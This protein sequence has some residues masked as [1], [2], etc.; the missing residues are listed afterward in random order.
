M[1]AARETSRDKARHGAP[2]GFETRGSEEAIIRYYEAAGP[3]YEAWSKNFN[4][5]FGF[6]RW[7]LNPFNRERMLEETTRQ[8]FKRLRLSHTASETA[9]D[10]GCGLG[11]SMRTGARFF[12]RLRLSG[13]TLVPWQIERAR[14]LTRDSGC[15]NRLSYCHGN[16]ESLPYAANQFDA[17]YAIESAVY[18]QGAGKENLVQ[19]A[20]RVLRS[21]GHFVIFDCFLKRPPEK[22]NPLVRYC[23]KQVCRGWAVEEM[24]QIEPFTNALCVAGFTVVEREDISWQV[25]PSVAHAPFV[26]LRFFC[27]KLLL[28]ERLSRESLHHLLSC[29]L[30]CLLGLDRRSFSYFLLTCR[31]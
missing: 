12:P 11:A 25:A 27:G 17:C 30:A 22:M 7:P 20:Y 1:K 29:A 18:A 9:V 3:D 13:V 21:G 16:Y 4:M 23:Y 10:L 8:V 6:W 5:H 2:G 15:E 28:G 19:E 14:V 26:T 31:K 24:A